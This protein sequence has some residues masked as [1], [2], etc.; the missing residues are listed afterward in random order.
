MRSYGQHSREITRIILCKDK[1][2]FIFY[3]FYRRRPIPRVNHI[4]AGCICAMLIPLISRNLIL[5]IANTKQFFVSVPIKIDE[6]RRHQTADDTAADSA[7]AV[8]TL[9]L[10]DH[11]NIRFRTV[12]RILIH[13]MLTEI[14]TGRR[15]VPRNRHIERR[16]YR[17]NRQISRTI[18]QHW[19]YRIA[20]CVT[21]IEL[22]VIHINRNTTLYGNVLL[23]QRGRKWHTHHQCCIQQASSQPLA[24]YFHRLIFM[25]VHTFSPLLYFE[26]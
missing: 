16:R 11:R 13:L 14:R 21:R 8:L 9:Q 15:S 10:L 1:R 4:F 18:I 25:L 3:Q 19:L 5:R 12:Y 24:E 2:H 26:C 7:L 17:A 23:C 20:I 6:H 22:L